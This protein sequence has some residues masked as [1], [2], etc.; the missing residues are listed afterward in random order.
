V[1]QELIIYGSFFFALFFTGIGIPPLPEELPVIT[2]GIAASHNNVRWFLAWP[3]CVLGVVAADL[4]LYWAGRGFGSRLFEYRWVRNFLPPER[5]QKIEEGFHQNGLKILLSARL[6]PGLRSG[7]YMT[8]GAMRYPFIRFLLADAIYAIPGVGII[9]F[10]S[11]FLAE[12]VW[13]LIDQVHKVQYWLLALVLLA[14]G[15]FAL[16]RYFRVA[17]EHAAHD[18]LHAPT[19]PELIHSTHMHVPPSTEDPATHGSTGDGAPITPT[20]SESAKVSP[21]PAENHP[22]A[23]PG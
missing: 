15:G 7:V 19:I 8:A 10:L 20:A 12:S 22:P 2:A 16:Y 18:D 23:T 14:G 9:F 11:Y 1:L 21:P 6:L 4:V 13:L 17:R 3:A 5:R